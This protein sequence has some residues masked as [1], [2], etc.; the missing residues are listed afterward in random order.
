M[1]EILDGLALAKYFAVVRFRTCFF[2]V[3]IDIGSFSGSVGVGLSLSGRGPTGSLFRKLVFLPL[4]LRIIDRRFVLILFD[5]LQLLHILFMFFFSEPGLAIALL[6]FL[7]LSLPLFLSLLLPRSLTF[8]LLFNGQFLPLQLIPFLLFSEF[9]PFLGS[10]QGLV[11]EII[12]RVDLVTIFIPLPFLQELAI[13]PQPVSIQEHHSKQGNNN[14]KSRNHEDGLVL[15][16]SRPHLEHQ[17]QDEQDDHSLVE[18]EHEGVDLLGVGAV[19]GDIDQ[20]ANR[21]PAQDVQDVLLG[22]HEGADED[23]CGLVDE[24]DWRVVLLDQHGEDEGFG[25]DAVD[26]DGAHQGDDD[27]DGDP[28][29][30][31]VE[32]LA[33][34]GVERGHIGE[35]GHDGGDDQEHAHEGC[36]KKDPLEHEVEGSGGLLQLDLVFDQILLFHQLLGL[37]F[38]VELLGLQEQADYHHQQQHD[39]HQV[40]R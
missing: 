14:G 10:L 39:V 2:A 17:Q 36:H 15:S 4:V 11:S 9:V 34:H 3:I 6:K 38:V 24:V 32:F 29:P 21:H 25:V 35:L 33:H 26:D 37:P 23:E 30:Q 31:Q 19:D 1:L 12:L 27:G 7:H 5:F 40:V 8:L 16:R 18:D 28:S 20:E 22:V 13:P